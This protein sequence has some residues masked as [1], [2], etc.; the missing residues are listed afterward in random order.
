MTQ[1]DERALERSIARVR[2]RADLAVYRILCV[3]GAPPKTLPG[4]LPSRDLEVTNQVRLPAG[5]GEYR[6]G[7]VLSIDPSGKTV[8]VIVDG[9]SEVW[10]GPAGRA[11]RGA[12]RE[13]GGRSRWRDAH[14]RPGAGR[15]AS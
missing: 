14:S 2:R 12:D 8:E 11:Y 7:N 1:A 9:G 13:S 4:A 6:T 10:T 5:P 3:V 15:P